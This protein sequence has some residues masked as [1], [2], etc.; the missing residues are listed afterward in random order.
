MSDMIRQDDQYVEHVGQD[1][2][3][4]W[5]IVSPRGGSFGSAKFNKGSKRH[6]FLRDTPS[7]QSSQSQSLSPLGIRQA[8]LGMALRCCCCCCLCCSK[9]CLSVSV[10]LMSE[11]PPPSRPS[12]RPPARPVPPPP[13]PPRPAPHLYVQTPDRPPMRLLC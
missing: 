1:G 6:I 11:F 2:A 4:C 12:A 7:K 5:P 3:I 9:K 13:P 8:S 10:F